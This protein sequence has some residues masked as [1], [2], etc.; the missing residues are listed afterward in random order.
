MFL[1]FFGIIGNMKPF[2]A[3]A[4]PH[5]D[6]LEGR[7]TMDVFAAD[8]WEVFK[9]RAP[10]EYAN[11]NV[12]F[13]KTFL[14]TGLK[15]LLEIAEKRLRG[16]GGDPVIQIQTPFGGGKTHS[17]IAL[18]HK[19]K[20][21]NANTVVLVGTALDPKDTTLWEELEKQVT[22]GVEKLKGRI[23]PG[24]DKLREILQPALPI[25]ILMDEVLEFVTRAA[26]VKVGETSLAAQ[27]LAFMQELME[28][29]KTLDKALLIITLP[30]S[31]LEHYD[32]QAEK[33]FQQLQK[34]AGRVE[35]IY[36][37]VRDEEIEEVIRKRLFSDIK[38]DEAKNIIEEFLNYAEV[39]KILPAGI[40]KADYRRRF[41]RSY[42]FQ[43]EVIDVLYKRWG[44]FPT[45][46]RTRGVLRLLSLVVYSLKGSSL[47][48]IRLSDFK[49]ENDEIKRELI[50]HIGAE[51]DS[52]LAAD[53]TSKNS[54]AK[55]VDKMLS[56]AYQGFSFGTKAATAIF[57]CSFSGGIEKGATLNEIKLSCSELG[58]PSSVI[59]EVTEKLKDNLFYLQHQA[60][61]YYF[62][63][64]PNL[65]RILLTK[66]ESVKDEDV[67]VKEFELLKKNISNRF[68]TYIWPSTTKDVA[69]TPKHKLVIMKNFDKELCKRFMEE[70]GERPRIYRNTLIFLC[71]LESERTNFENNV[72]KML[73]YQLIEKDKTLKLTNEQ[74]KE[75]KTNLRDAGKLLKEHIRGFYR[76]LLVPSKDGFKDIDLGLPTFGAGKKIDEEVYE[77]LRSEGELLEKLSPL[78]VKEKY[79][80]SD[81]V[82]TK[83]IWDSTLKTPGEIRL[84][85]QDVLKESIKEG[86]KQGI[87][88]IGVLKDGKAEC[89]HFKEKVNVELVE[90]E[91]IIKPELCQAE[92]AKPKVEIEEK[93]EVKAKLEEKPKVVT[94]MPKE[95]YTNIYL[96]LRVPRGK[97]SDFARM[98]NFLQSKFEDVE[99]RVEIT[100]KSG[101]ITISEYD[102]KIREALRQSNIEVEEEKIE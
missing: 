89:C 78:I 31:L 57:L 30:S 33:F 23:A 20:E 86:V 53:I 46:Q 88:G 74:L 2:H 69:D 41:T 36:T 59:V 32:E 87:F 82:E 18:Y 77:S 13:K 40:D 48:F 96:K 52:V 34:I 29:V 39:E 37:P 73:A 21:W 101:S 11:P 1:Y 62:T 17:L 95:A 63:N 64:Q 25:L 4:V 67:R 84:S 60:G 12:F 81:F 19:A 8:L 70:Y 7:L 38:L 91:V 92:V 3:I 66:M 44:S 55:K 79:L 49:L 83:N 43:P 71:P 27:T 97:I 68:E 72:K 93:E 94:I 99:L 26:G 58:I 9:G 90:G 45:F 65:N 15:N 22:G 54:N 10:D 28:V 61:K 24:R 42:P 47:P 85:S 6:I 56:D 98:V 50:K 35:K 76:L 75:V 102:D 51:Y 16:E 80:K 100:T 5:R 14:T